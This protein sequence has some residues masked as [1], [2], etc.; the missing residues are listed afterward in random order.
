MNTPLLDHILYINLDIRTDR[1]EHV[2]E[3]L[4][5]LN[6]PPYAI[7]RF[8]AI[9]HPLNGAIGCTMSHIRCLEIAKERG[10]PYVFICEDDLT[11]LDPLGLIEK[12]QRFWD[13]P[14]SQGWDVLLI[15]SNILSYRHFSNDAIQV[16][17]CYAPTGYIIQQSYYDTLLEN[18]RKGLS[19]FI[20]HP[21]EPHHYAVDVVWKE[22]HSPL[23]SRWFMLIPPTAIQYPNFS[24]I[25]N[26]YVDHRES[27]LNINK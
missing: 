9:P 4:N 18:Y 11:F 26:R 1:N 19:L 17:S 22:L 3:E 23:D 14:P 8:P 6:P 25:D 12:I 10:Y 2:I 16:H 21:N 20:E 13:H 5:K 15:C 27:L 7:E 24:N